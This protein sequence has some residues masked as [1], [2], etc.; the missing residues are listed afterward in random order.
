MT[1]PIAESSASI[2]NGT[3][4]TTFDALTYG[5]A[6]AEPSMKDLIHAAVD[7]A[8]A[9]G[10][11]EQ[12]LD[13]SITKAITSALQDM[14]GAYSEFGKALKKQLAES[15]ACGPDLDL[16]TYG[17]LVLQIVRRQVDAAVGQQ[18][19]GQIE[20]TLKDLLDSPPAS[21]KLTEIVAQFIE[22]HHERRELGARKD[23]RSISLH[24]NTSD[25]GYRYISIDPR[26]GKDD[27]E[28]LVCIGVNRDDRVFT[29]SIDKQ[30]FEKRLFTGPL[31]GFER[32]LFRL[33]ANK[34][35]IEFDA[36]PSRIE[37]V[38][39]DSED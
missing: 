25:G 34:T 13:A 16:P 17:H 12:T 9:S 33:Y 27:G 35:P 10:L 15:L 5:I 21:I 31:Y 14:T 22:F 3:P 39:P 38:Y 18:M 6:L 20:E 28:C 7:R 30:E 37:L 32:L 26:S 2:A 36:E 24:V 19:H 1:D 11:V 4:P 29:L 23:S 8:I